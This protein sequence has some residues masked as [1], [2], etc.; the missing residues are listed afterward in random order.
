[1][2]EQPFGQ[3]NESRGTVALILGILGLLL[4]QPLGIGAVILGNQ[5]VRELSPSHEQYAL[6]N[7]G[8]ILGWIAIAL[9]LL[10]LVM[11]VGAFG[12]IFLA[13]ASGMH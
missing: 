10:V 9:F 8:R 5:V 13:A 3:R 11:V 12:L 4:F 7:V 1:M 2:Y 6:G